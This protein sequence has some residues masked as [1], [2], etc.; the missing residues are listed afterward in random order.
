L[1]GVEIDPAHRMRRLKDL[2]NS[3]LPEAIAVG[4]LAAI[5]RILATH[6]GDGVGL[7][8]LGIDSAALG[9]TRA[10]EVPE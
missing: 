3:A 5:E 6:L 4:D 1:H 10:T 9:L 7:V 8:R 2:A